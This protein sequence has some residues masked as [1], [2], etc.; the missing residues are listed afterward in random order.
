MELPYPAFWTAL[1][2]ILLLNHQEFSVFEENKSL[3]DLT[4]YILKANRVKLAENQSDQLLSL[5]LNMLP[6]GLRK[7]RLA[8][9]A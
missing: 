7:N 9:K 1:V 3:V 5:D 6:S 2:N 8:K 4:Y